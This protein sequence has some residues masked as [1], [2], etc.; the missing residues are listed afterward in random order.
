MKICTVVDNLFYQCY[1]Y[2]II[3]KSDEA[4]SP[5]AELTQKPAIPRLAG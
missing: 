5:I 3:I 1:L 4:N 2:S